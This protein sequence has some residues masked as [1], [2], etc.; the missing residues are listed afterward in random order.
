MPHDAI[1]GK[2]AHLAKDYS[3]SC[4]ELRFSETKL[5]ALAVTEILEDK[6]EG[7][8]VVSRPLVTYTC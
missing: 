2:P 5:P 7:R 4:R 1:W 3:P 6:R 8:S